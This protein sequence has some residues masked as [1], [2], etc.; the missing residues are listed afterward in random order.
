MNLRTGVE[1]VEASREKRPVSD[2]ARFV[3]HCAEDEIYRLLALHRN[4]KTGRE[5][6]NGTIKPYF[7]DGTTM[8]KEEMK[9]DLI[10]SQQA[11]ID[12]LHALEARVR[13]RI[14]DDNSEQT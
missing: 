7:P 9:A 12:E 8:T 5:L 3:A 1:K 6:I 4:V 10:K 11:D 13:A 2:Q 14:G